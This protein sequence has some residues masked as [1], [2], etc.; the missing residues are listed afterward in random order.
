MLF[1]A[2]LILSSL[3]LT[4][5]QRCVG[6]SLSLRAR[7]CRKVCAD[8]C[9]DLR[10]HVWEEGWPLRR[11]DLYANSVGS[12]PLIAANLQSYVP[13]GAAEDKQTCCAD[14]LARDNI[15]QWS[16]EHLL[17]KKLGGLQL[18]SKT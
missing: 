5:C 15:R 8:K 4:K 10:L 1:A 17:K 3:Q 12:Y 13:A 7:A 6:S 16:L 9:A 14:L 11:R 2:A 18:D